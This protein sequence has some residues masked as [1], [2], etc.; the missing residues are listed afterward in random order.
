M[1]WVRCRPIWDLGS[2]VGPE[3]KQKI[4]RYSMTAVDADADKGSYRDR[5]T[6][7]KAVGLLDV[8]ISQ[9]TGGEP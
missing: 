4:L 1:A 3:A 9:L 8:G 5:G 7:I 2:A 6:G